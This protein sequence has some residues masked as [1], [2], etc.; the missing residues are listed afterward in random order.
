MSILKNIFSGSLTGVIDSVSDVIDKFS[1]SKEEKQEFKL[2]MQSRLMQ[3]EKELEETYRAELES[4]ADIIKAEMTQGD[5][6]TKRAR[7]AIIYSGLI[8]ILLVYVLIPLIA[9]ISGAPGDALPEIELPE[10]FWWAWGTVVSVYGA[11][12]SAEKMGFSNR[13]TQMMT[14]SG[15]NRMNK[16]QNVQG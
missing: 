8:F 4:R 13:A 1:L 2:E 14:G 7:P 15:A 3:M 12:R 9:Y 10:E 6:F 5:K 11:G 16:S